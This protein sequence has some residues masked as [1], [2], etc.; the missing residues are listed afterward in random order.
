MSLLQSSRCRKVVRLFAGPVLTLMVLSGCGTLSQIDGLRPKFVPANK[1]VAGEYLKARF[2]ARQ[3]QLGVAA[4][5]YVE[6]A[7]GAPPETGVLHY[8]FFYALAAGDVENAR[9]Y[10]DKLLHTEM[11]KVT[12]AQG[13]ADGVASALASMQRPQ[14]SNA[15]PR[16]TIAVDQLRNSDNQAALK[17][18]DAE[19]DSVFAK[20]VGR[21]IRVWALYEE[22]GPAAALE[23]LDQTPKDVF[24][25][26][27]N[28]HR[29]LLQERLGEIDAAKTAWQQS[30]TPYSSELDV[31]LYARFLERHGKDGEALDTYQ[32]M[33]GKT[34]GIARAGRLGLARLGM[35]VPDESAALIKAARKDQPVGVT[36]AREG[37]ALALVQFSWAG[38]QQAVTERAN[39]ARAGFRNMPPMLNTQLA[40]S[41]LANSLDKNMTEADYLIGLIYVDYDLPKEAIAALKNV[42]PTSTR[43]EYSAMAQAQAM[44]DLKNTEGSKKL[45]TKFV[46]QD[47]L[48]VDAMMYLIDYL[49][50]DEN[51]DKAISVSSKMIKRAEKYGSQERNDI[52][53]WRQYFQRGTANIQADLFENGV[54]DLQQAIKLAPEE[55]MVL[56]YLGYS[57]AEKGVNLDEAF[58]MLEKALAMRPDSGAIVDSIGW[59]H[60]QLGDINTALTYIEQA[61]G[62]EPADPVVT[63]HLGDI[64]W[65]LGR[66]MEARYE[67][68]RAQDH[69]PDAKLTTSLEQKLLTGLPQS[70]RPKR[71]PAKAKPKPATD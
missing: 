7:K 57:W 14:P 26:F 54:A 51:Y 48:S 25:G 33:V 24:T 70:G 2:A 32:K 41:Q 31:V 63:D 50:Q 21:L 17:T 23:V 68:R 64:Y 18:L 16:L 15:L 55:P 30:V 22:Q 46:E 39:A 11:P 9:I 44:E 8:A 35:A 20:S 43:Y 49:Q 28:V 19:F 1:S 37:A 42:A 45:L 53:L 69:E 65:V 61:V 67:W 52:Y 29:A 71:L 40:F 56:N 34:G 5:A 38:Y 47:P 13:A 27:D 62:M 66:K 58:A 3:Q 60:Y 4:E 59:A 36:S 12:P 10:A 6:A